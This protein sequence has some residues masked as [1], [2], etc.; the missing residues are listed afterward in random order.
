M[1]AAA[2]KEEK[3]VELEAGLT[4]VFA[5]ILSRIGDDGKIYGRAGMRVDLM[6]CRQLLNQLEDLT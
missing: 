3:L 2:Q 4:D 1:S 5:T 6:R